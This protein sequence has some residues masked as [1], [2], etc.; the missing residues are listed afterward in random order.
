MSI[1]HWA[2]SRSILGAA[3]SACI[4]ARKVLQTSKRV[5]FCPSFSGGVAPVLA[6]TLLSRGGVEEAVLS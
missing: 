1:L 2:I 5:S 4:R 3:T 6:P